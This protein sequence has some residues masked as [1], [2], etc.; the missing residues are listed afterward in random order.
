MQDVMHVI[1][2]TDEFQERLLRSARLADTQ[3]VLAGW[4]DPLNQQ[5]LIDD[6]YGGIEL[7]DNCQWW[8]VGTI[9]ISFAGFSRLVA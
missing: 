8:R 6:D 3:Q 1:I 2:V 5:A 7:V 9:R 4:I